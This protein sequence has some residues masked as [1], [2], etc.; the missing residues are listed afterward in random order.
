MITARG[1]HTHGKDFFEA[2]EAVLASPKHP[3]LPL[4]FLWGRTIELLLKSYLLSVGVSIGRLRSREFG[5]NLIALHK[6]ARAQGVDPLIGS[7]PKITGLMQLLNFEYGNKRLEYRETGTYS[8]PDSELACAVIRRLLKGVD[9]HLRQH[10][11]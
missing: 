9:S 7:D 6:E 8:L 4:A 11:I 10:D 5:H 3:M 1:F 2:A